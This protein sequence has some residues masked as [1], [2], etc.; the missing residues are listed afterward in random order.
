M[1]PLTAAQQ[2][3]Q[4]AILIL[5]PIAQGAPV[6]K[7]GFGDLPVNGNPIIIPAQPA[8]VVYQTNVIQPSDA[9]NLANGLLVDSSYL[10]DEDTAKTLS[11]EIGGGV[12]YL[13]PQVH[14]QVGKSGRN[15][16]FID[17]QGRTGLIAGKLDETKKRGGI[18]KPGKWDLSPGYHDLWQIADST[19]PNAAWQNGTGVV[20][21]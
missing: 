7:G 21:L 5:M 4:N 18:G 11:L 14:V 15:V 9:I 13:S 12:P 1:D 10:T 19:D 20:A 8:K 2:A 16:W 3:A 6:S 17:A